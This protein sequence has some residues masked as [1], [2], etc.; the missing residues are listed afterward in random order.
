MDRIAV[1]LDSWIGIKYLL[2]DFLFP[3]RCNSF[4]LYAT[5]SNKF[6]GRYAA[7]YGLCLSAIRFLSQ[8]SPLRF[9]LLLGSMRVLG[10]NC[11]Y[12][13]TRGDKGFPNHHIDRMRSFGIQLCLL[14]FF[15]RDH[16][17][18][19]IDNCGTARTIHW[20]LEI[21]CSLSRADRWCHCPQSISVAA[22]LAGTWK[23]FSKLQV[24]RRF[25]SLRL[26]DS[27]AH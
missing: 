25:R 17:F 6:D 23:A 22:L 24:S 15:F 19:S 5:V 2:A 3:D 21:L 1:Y 10:G 12:L 11:D 8:Y 26:E 7:R 13:A 27:P 9:E 14:C 20:A 16:H 4:L 18:C